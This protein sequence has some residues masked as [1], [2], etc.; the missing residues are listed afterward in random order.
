MYKLWLLPADLNDFV[1]IPIWMTYELQD[2]IKGLKFG[3]G[4]T[5]RSLTPGDNYNDFHLPA[6]GRFDL[7][8]SY[9]TQVFNKSVN[10]I[11]SISSK[12]LDFMVAVNAESF[13]HPN[14]LHW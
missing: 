4:V 6:Y 3:G 8:S 1:Q 14:H 7:M 10:F 11:C 2:I 5:A 9:E 13:L 12:Y